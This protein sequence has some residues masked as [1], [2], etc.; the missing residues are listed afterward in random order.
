MCACYKSSPDHHTGENVC[1]T[2][3]VILESYEISDRTV[4]SI[5]HNQE[6]NMRRATNLLQVEQGWA[7][8]NCSAHILQL[9]IND[10]FK[11]N[12][13]IDRALGAAR[14][15]VSNFYQSTLA[16]AELYKQQSQMNM[17]Q[18]KLKIDC[19]TRWNSI[20]YMIKHL[21]ANRWSVSAVLSDTIVPKGKTVP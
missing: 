6:S 15:L 19:A 21:V 14:K 9:C 11:N 18:Q 8:V 7:G 17:D 20:L 2:I 12:A 13:S 1:S 3:K 16:M 4:S 10:G 5:V